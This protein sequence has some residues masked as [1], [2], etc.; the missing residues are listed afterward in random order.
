M[1]KDGN[2]LTEKEMYEI[3][4]VPKKPLSHDIFDKCPTCGVLM[5][6]SWRRCE[7][8]GQLLLISEK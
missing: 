4:F 1:D 5:S 7:K 6:G 8:C 3:L 2:F